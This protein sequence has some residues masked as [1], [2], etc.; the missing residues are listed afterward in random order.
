MYT[1]QILK[2]KFMKKITLLLLIIFPSLVI[3]QIQIGQ[4]IDGEAANDL[5]GQSVAISLD[6]NRVA[7]GAPENGSSGIRSGHV[8]VYENQGGNW[9]Q[10]GQDID[11]DTISAESGTSVSLSSDG[12]IIAIGAPFHGGGVFT[13]RGQ[14]RIFSFNGS[15]WIQ[16]GTE[17]LGELESEFGN[18]VS[19]SSDGNIIAIGAPEALNPSGVGGMGQT[20]IYN[21][22]GSDWIQMGGDINGTS[23]RDRSGTSVS[24]SLD[25]TIVAIGSPSRINAF[26]GTTG[27][28]RVFQFDGSSWNI[29]GQTINGDNNDRLGAVVSLSSDGNIFAASASG[30]TRLYK[31][32]S[33]MWSQVGSDITGFQSKIS[34]S[35]DGNIIAIGTTFIDNSTTSGVVKIFENQS[36]IWTQIGSDIFGEFATDQLG[37]AVAISK[38]RTR[39]IAGTPRNDDN[40]INSGH[41]RVFDISPTTLSTNDFISSEFKLFPN[42]ASDILN[43]ELQPGVVLENINL[44]N[45]IGQFMS[46][47]K[48]LTIDTSNLS[49]GIYFVEIITGLGKA[50]KKLIID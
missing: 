23:S 20:R 32:I 5:S 19:L 4:D 3:G 40:G 11:G 39:L 7:I 38:D 14:V 6:G 33:G 18:S 9:I 21:F 16:M 10:I 17:I 24:L 15:S 8:R 45:N 34:L 47:T 50:T 35:S 43:I 12:N 28:L 41:A 22:N 1:L 42:P 37:R 26:V 36:D 27:Q 30:F 49:Q 2:L 25:G 31:N 13:T 29:L 44:Y 48:S 46:S